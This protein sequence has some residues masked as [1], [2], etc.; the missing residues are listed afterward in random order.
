MV[1]GGNWH[2]TNDHKVM[3][4]VKNIDLEYPSPNEEWN[5]LWAASTS[6]RTNHVIS[7]LIL[8]GKSAI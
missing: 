7:S 6:L 4:H 1:T 3:K 2:W 5:V 8:H